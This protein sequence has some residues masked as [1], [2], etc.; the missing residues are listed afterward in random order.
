MTPELVVQEGLSMQ[1]S[2]RHTYA[3]QFRN[4]AAWRTLTAICALAIAVPLLTG[5]FGTYL[6]CVIACYA[7]A[8]L[9]LQLMVGVAGQL[10]LGHAAFMAV[11][12]YVTALAQMRLGLSFF[13]AAAL[14][15]LASALTGLLMAQLIRLSGVYFKI[16]TFGFGVIVYQIISNWSSV[17]GGHT[18]ITRIPP[19]Q[20][21]G[22]SVETRTQLFLV[23]AV[24]L[25]VAY[26]LT[27]RMVQGR[28]GRALLA[29]GQNE[30][31]A[32]AIGV[33]VS[34]YKMA[35]IVFGCSLGGLGGAFLPQLNGFLNP[36]TFTWA[37]SL[38]LLIMITVGGL[39]SL[40]GAVV[41]TAVLILVPEYLRDVAEYKM[42]LFG[43][44]LVLAL[45]FMPRGLAGAGESLVRMI[46]R[47][48]GVE[49]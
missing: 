48:R 21:F 5:S 45:M 36:D 43:I 20:F 31:A 6:G 7:I 49:R 18:G 38:L 14:G 46:G 33:N 13:P 40:P 16:A 17:T 42:L 26:V 3:F 47:R 19:I 24:A 12:S 32:E 8:T 27:L 23:I 2:K 10:S 37:E 44:L 34:G 29:I 39:G 22:W 25:V 9:G 15:V 41:G 28:A 4:Q 35:V 1:P 30:P 11:G